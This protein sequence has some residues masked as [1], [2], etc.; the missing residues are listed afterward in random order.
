M[1]IL[2]Q[3]KYALF[4]GIPMVEIE[5]SILNWIQNHLSTAY[6]NDFFPTIT[7]LGNG[8]IL[9]I[10]LTIYFLINKK[11]R[12]IGLCMGIAL[13]LDLMLCNVILKPLIARA[14]PFAQAG[15]MLTADQ[16]L[17]SPPGDFSFPS[18][19]TAASFAAA[20]ALYLNDRKKGLWALAVAIVISFS[21]LYLYV[22]YPTDVLGGVVVGILC[23]YLSTKIVKKIFSRRAE[24]YVFDPEHKKELG[25]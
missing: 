9:W 13:L 14:R 2:I 17:I 5:L 11:T 22:H 16:L 3:Y 23:G 1:A 4:G 21:R 24:I 7:V 8:G 19:H 10:G 20:V 12:R 15:T 25:E 18:G 6:L